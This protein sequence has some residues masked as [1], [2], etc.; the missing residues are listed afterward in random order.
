MDETITI[1]FVGHA[2]VDHERAASSYEDDVLPLL[3]DHGATLVYRGRRAG[4][5][6]PALPYEVHLIRFPGRAAYDGYLDDVRRQHLL[7]THGEVFTSKV[8][9]ELDTI[10]GVAE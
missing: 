3:A 9:V 8:V 5:Q 4:G 2:A 7:D 10:A 1:A 6:D